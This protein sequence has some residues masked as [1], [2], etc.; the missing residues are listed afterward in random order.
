MAYMSDF[1]KDID[2]SIELTAAKDELATNGNE[3]AKVGT[4]DESNGNCTANQINT[5]DTNNVSVRDRLRGKRMTKESKENALNMKFWIPNLIAQGHHIV[6]YGAAGSGKTTVVLYMCL[7]ILSEHEDAEVY[8]L[9]ADG[10]IAMAARFENY[11]EG[12]G[13]SERYNILTE[14]LVEENLGLI[15]ELVRSN[16]ARAKNIIVVIDTLKYLN[17][18]INNKDSNVKAMQRIK[19]LTNKGIT[20]ISL[21]HTNKDGENYSGTADIEQDSD[22]LF[23][24]VTAPGDDPKNK[25]STIEEG[26]RVRYFMEPRS[27]SF[28]QGDP[29]SV[30]ELES[31]INPQQ[32]LQQN[33]DAYAISVIKATLNV[34]GEMTKTDLEKI[35]NDDDGFDYSEKERKRIL[36]QYKDKHW[37]V[38][39]GGDKNR[40]HFYSSID[41]TAEVIDSINEKIAVR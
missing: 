24:I 12:Q 16:E 32:L 1:N 30:K 13:F 21:H 37:K 5:Q 9:Y 7:L 20:V 35:L 39:K 26:G 33:Q 15:E 18:N 27:Y 36:K 8:Y 22:A 11:C 31:V 25:I 14:G 3:T 4:D 40:K 29:S 38:K 2:N 6:L 17:P 28:T 34:E 19:Q 10:Q 23:K 41:N